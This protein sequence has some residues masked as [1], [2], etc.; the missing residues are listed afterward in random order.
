MKDKE[1]LCF[2]KGL[3]K[4][5]AEK[6]GAKEGAGYDVYI[7]TSISKAMSN[8]DTLLLHREFGMRASILQS[9]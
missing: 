7:C 9:T 3:R 5:Q 4:V 2:R 6:N 1:K 8:Y